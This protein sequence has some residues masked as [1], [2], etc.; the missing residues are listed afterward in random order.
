MCNPQLVPGR[1]AVIEVNFLGGREII[2][3]NWY[4]K[5][6]AISRAPDTKTARAIAAGWPA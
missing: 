5:V 6:M 4:D 2:D 3:R 1:P